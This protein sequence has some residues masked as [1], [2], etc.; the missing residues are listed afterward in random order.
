M[1]NGE[2]AL[3][4]IVREVASVAVNVRNSIVG[5]VQSERA[6]IRNFVAGA[7]FTTE[8]GHLENGFASIAG[9]GNQLHVTGQVRRLWAPGTG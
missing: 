3:W 4:V 2:G 9:A 8:Q 6:D 5:I 1:S 7:V